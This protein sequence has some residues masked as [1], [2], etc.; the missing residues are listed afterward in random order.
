MNITSERMLVCLVEFALLKWDGDMQVSGHSCNSREE[1]SPTTGLKSSLSVFV[2]N[3]PLQ[4]IFLY[5]S[6]LFR[7][8]LNIL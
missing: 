5:I 3:Q 6:A 7:I 4:I 8:I 1:R 2:N